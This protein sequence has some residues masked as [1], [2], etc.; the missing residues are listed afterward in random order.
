MTD[1][2]AGM[3]QTLLSVRLRRFYDDGK[4]DEFDF[5]PAPT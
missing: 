2:G 1:E 5:T 3:G 4:N